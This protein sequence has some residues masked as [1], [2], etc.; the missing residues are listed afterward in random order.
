[1]E[2]DNKKELIKENEDL[3]QILHGIQID[4]TGK[5]ERIRE[6]A[7]THTYHLMTAI[8]IVAGFGFTA[9]DS[10]QFLGMFLVGESFLFVG[11]ALAMWFAKAG[12]IDEMGYTYRWSQ[13]IHTAIQNR[14]QMRHKFSGSD[15]VAI[16]SKMETLRENDLNLFKKDTIIG[17]DHKWLTRIFLVFI[18]GCAFILLS[19]IVICI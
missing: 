14:I 3:I 17:A 19:F 11:M 2:S 9:I 4:I 13:N 18:L 16:K 15:F 8:G 10:I 7:L 5:H 6:R 12:F 1:M